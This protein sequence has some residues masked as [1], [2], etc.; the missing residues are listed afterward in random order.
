MCYK[1][2]WREKVRDVFAYSTM[3]G[4]ETNVNSPG[5][6]IAKD[7]AFNGLMGNSRQIHK[8]T[9]IQI[10]TTHVCTHNLIY[11]PKIYN[12]SRSRYVC[13]F[14]NEFVTLKNKT[15][16]P[17]KLFYRFSF[18]KTMLR[19]FQGP[20]GTKTRKTC[21]AFCTESVLREPIL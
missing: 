14:V 13:R 10:H 7:T 8:H 4:A 20:P 6:H 3:T 5:F 11:L 1:T 15:K 16:S 17:D 12:A 9:W 2:R 21:F 19:H 18:K